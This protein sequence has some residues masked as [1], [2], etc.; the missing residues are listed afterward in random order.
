MEKTNYRGWNC[1]RLINDRYE[2]FVTADMGP[3]I[4]HFSLKGEENIFK[5]F[6][7]DTGEFI[8]NDWHVCG[9]HRLWHAPEAI[10]RSYIPDNDPPQIKEKGNKTQF[11][12]TI[13]KETGIQKEI[14]ILLDNSGEVVIT[15]RLKNHN[16]WD[17]RTAVW[18][19]S[20][21]REGGRNIL[22][23]PPRGRH[24]DQDIDPCNTITMWPFTD[25]SDERWYLG[26]EYF[27]LKN[28]PGKEEGQKIAM[29]VPD[30][31]IACAVNNNLFI[32]KFT[33]NPDAEY[34]DSGCNA[35]VFTNSAILE[36]ETMGPMV[37]IKPGEYIEH[38]ERWQI[39]KGVALPN[40]DE[41]IAKNILPL[42]KNE[43]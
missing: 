22:P 1:Y 25:F 4:V 9:G 19:L 6:D 5:T 30:E 8:I 12:A 14:E 3:R 42:I 34:P 43:S 15:H 2:L 41:D 40:N 28:T 7:P 18:A 24:E 20:V 36:L 29:L 35:A 37:N 27:M 21:M 31:W 11:T 33:Y 16:L 39:Q 13:E 17:V 26:K 38:D 10:P 32:K 23:L